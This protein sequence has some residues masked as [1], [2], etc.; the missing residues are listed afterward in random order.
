MYVSVCSLLFQTNT[1]G[2]VYCSQL[3]QNANVL[4][5]GRGD[6]VSDSFLKQDTPFFTVMPVKQITKKTTSSKQE[7]DTANRYQADQPIDV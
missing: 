6:L 1:T 5:R 7:K 4:L 2:L 3:N